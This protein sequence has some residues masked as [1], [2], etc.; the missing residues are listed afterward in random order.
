MRQAHQR[1]WSRYR[2]G[3]GLRK[4]ARL[5]LHFLGLLGDFLGR[6]GSLL[7]FLRFLCH[8]FLVGLVGLTNVRTLRTS[9][10]AIKL[11][12]NQQKLYH[13]RLTRVL[14]R[15][16]LAIMSSVDVAPTCGLCDINDG[17]D[18]APQFV[19]SHRWLLELDLLGDI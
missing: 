6:L 2:G 4:T 3:F 1:W 9:A 15:C 19:D 14:E 17:V 8:V 18:D 16:S 10:R 5:L 7:C 13:V 11:T 12:R